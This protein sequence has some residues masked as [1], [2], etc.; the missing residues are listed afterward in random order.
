MPLSRYLV[1]ALLIG[2]L[3][4]QFGFQDSRYAIKLKCC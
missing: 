2:S 4:M 1:G 3:T